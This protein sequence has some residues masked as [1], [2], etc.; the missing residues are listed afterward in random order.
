MVQLSWPYMTTGKTTAV[1]HG[2]LFHV[3]FYRE[4]TQPHPLA[5]NWIKGLLS[6]ALPTRAR[7]S[8][9]YSQSLP[10]EACT[11]LLSLSIRG[12]TEWKSQSQKTNQNDHRD[13]SFVYLNETMNHAMQGHPRQMGYGGEFWQNVVHWRREWQTASAFLPW[14][15][16]E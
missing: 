16:H 15:P 7:P 12:Q 2:A 6:K 4:G 11:S 9:P 8:F 5:E 1:I 10:S 3:W 14:E 13:H